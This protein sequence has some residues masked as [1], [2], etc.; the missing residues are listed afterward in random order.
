MYQD[1]TAVAA[2]RL[3]VAAGAD[4]GGPVAEIGLGVT[5]GRENQVDF[6]PV[7]PVAPE[8]RSCLDEQ[9]RPMRVLAA[10]NR[11]PELVGEQP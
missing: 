3:G 5:E 9:N 4:Q 2:Q 11:R 7:V 1:R 6:L 10:V 8:R